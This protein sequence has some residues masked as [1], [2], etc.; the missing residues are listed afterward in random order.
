MIRKMKKLIKKCGIIYAENFYKLN[1]K[2]I[3]AG[4]SPLI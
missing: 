4:L 2:V 1:K 3:D